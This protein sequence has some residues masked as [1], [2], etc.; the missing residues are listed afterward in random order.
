M[1]YMLNFIGFWI[2]SYALLL[3]ILLSFLV[4]WFGAS[5]TL[6]FIHSVSL[7]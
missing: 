4:V 3:L 5:G 7:A 1:D 2:L 6:F